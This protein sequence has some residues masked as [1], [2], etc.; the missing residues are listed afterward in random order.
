MFVPGPHSP[1][2]MAEMTSVSL[3]NRTVP[4]RSGNFQMF[5]D[6]FWV[7]FF[8]KFQLEFKFSDIFK[9]LILNR[10]KLK[11][12]NYLKR[13]FLSI[14]FEIEFKISIQLLNEIHVISTM[15]WNVK[16]LILKTIQNHQEIS[17]WKKWL[18][19]IL[20]CWLGHHLNIQTTV[21]AGGSNAPGTKWVDTCV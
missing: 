5:A 7:L 3:R 15:S 18:T 11:R 16:K 1:R 4:S 19:K 8:F 9:F 20:S 13:L 21:I 14:L 6:I 17:E 12:L 10:C 2:P